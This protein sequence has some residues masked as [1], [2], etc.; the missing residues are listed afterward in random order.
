MQ[1]E[2]PLGRQALSW[3]DVKGW[4]KPTSFDFDARITIRDGFEGLCRDLP[5]KDYYRLDFRSSAVFGL[6]ALAL[7]G[8]I[9]V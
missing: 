3:L 4:L 9:V 2:Q 6:N 8:G 5:S 7:P 1:A